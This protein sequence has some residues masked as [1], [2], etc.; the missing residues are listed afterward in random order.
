MAL[1]GP[2][3]SLR[4][5]VG[6]MAL[7]ALPALGETGAVRQAL[8]ASEFDP[9]LPEH[10]V[11]LATARRGAQ[12]EIT[13]CRAEGI[14]VVSIFEDGYPER[15][16]TSEEQTPILYIQGEEQLLA[17][18][19]V[20]AL[21]GDEEPDAAALGA[22]ERIIATLAA[23]EW[24]LVAGLSPGAEEAAQRAA[25]AAGVPGVGVLASGFAQIPPEA[26][27]LSSAILASGGVLLSPL[28]ATLPPTA[29]TRARSARLIATQASALILTCGGV[30]SGAMQLARQAA[31]QGR[32]ILCVQ[33]P[34]GGGAEYE[35]VRALLG[36]PASTLP[37][38]LPSWRGRR[39][40]AGE[41]LGEE[42]LAQ[43]LPPGEAGLSAVLSQVL[44]AERADPPAERWWPQRGPARAG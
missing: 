18:G 31:T 6:L 30:R 5:A 12:A 16:R 36:A 4:S 24:G 35:G 23:S 3:D 11:L 39:Y 33:P 14:R 43:P 15:Q 41:K 19:G 9:Y 38:L 40:I 1:G 13:R 37:E 28:R 32:P 17:R 10:R 2:S 44:E 8:I 20:F 22:G 34:S 25:L 27:E 26:G 21:G 42:P 29:A 7:Q